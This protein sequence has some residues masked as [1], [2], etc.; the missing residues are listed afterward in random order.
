MTRLPAAL[1]A[2]LCIATPAL[3]TTITIGPRLGTTVPNLTDG[4]TEVSNGFSSRVAPYGGF[5]VNW[6]MRPGWSLQAEVNLAPQG[7]KRDGMQP[8][9]G[10]VPGLT[11]PPGTTLYADYNNTVKLDYIEI[12]VLAKLESSGT[13]RWFA[14]G[15]PF[16]G[17][18]I[19]AKTVTSGTSRIYFDRAGTQE[20][21]VPPPPDPNAQ[22]L[23][24]QSLD[25]TTDEKSS[26]HTFNW[27]AQF[28]VGAERTAG[29][30]DV[31]LEVRGGIGL[32]NIQ[33]DPADG[34]SHTGAL[35]VALGYAWRVRE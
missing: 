28:G 6:A 27:G 1:A 21:M 18:L 35:V 24:P 4:G 34:R 3:A 15:G 14:M 29:A 26:L 9:T 19:S 11:L 10:D 7:G 2:L 32:A 23:G 12:P 31:F 8:I 5:F 17:F 25:A 22:P 16:V 30:G 20:V 33:K 13:V